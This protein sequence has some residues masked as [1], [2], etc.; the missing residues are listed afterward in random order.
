[1]PRKTKRKFVLNDPKFTCFKP[2]WVPRRDIEKIEILVDEF[3][4]FRLANYEWL[5]H[6]EWAKKMKTSPASFN[7]L[8]KSAEK[9]IA[10][11]LINGKWIRINKKDGTFDC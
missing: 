7:R 11:A 9:K 1:M 6:C 2:L 8:L 3:E 4:A 5:L 10:D